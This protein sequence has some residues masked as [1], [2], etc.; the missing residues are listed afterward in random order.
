M[1]GV[2][3]IRTAVRPTVR[4]AS[5]LTLA[6]ANAGATVTGLCSGWVVDAR[7]SVRCHSRSGGHDSQ[8]LCL[9]CVLKFPKEYKIPA[10][11][12][13]YAAAWLHLHLHGMYA[14]SVASSGDVRVHLQFPACRRLSKL[15]RLDA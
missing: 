5:R 7:P 1:W 4:K 2:G 14:A 9:S 8:N 12:H 13:A 15:A 10:T 3:I 6:E 11:A